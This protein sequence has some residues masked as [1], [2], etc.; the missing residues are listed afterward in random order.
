M[1]WETVQGFG[2]KHLKERPPCLAL[3]SLGT[4]ANLRARVPVVRF[5]KRM[6]RQ[7]G[8][9][10]EVSHEDRQ[11]AGLKKRAVAHW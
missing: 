4:W 11:R 5:E 2:A 7:T 10:R 8:E 6:A 9:C 3:L 1:E